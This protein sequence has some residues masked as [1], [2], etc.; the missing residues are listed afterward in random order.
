MKFEVQKIKQYLQNNV[1]IITSKKM[2]YSM[3]VSLINVY[4]EEYI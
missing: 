2:V 3:L 1:L 4:I